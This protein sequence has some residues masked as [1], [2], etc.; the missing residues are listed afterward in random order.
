MSTPE[1]LLLNLAENGV[2]AGVQ[3]GLQTVGQ[4]AAQGAMNAVL[5]PQLE[6]FSSANE[7]RVVELNEKT[8]PIL[9]LY[10]EILRKKVGINTT[11]LEPGA[12]SVGSGVSKR[13]R[14]IASRLTHIDLGGKECQINIINVELDPPA[15]IL[16]RAYT[17]F[18]NTLIQEEMG[19]AKSKIVNGKISSEFILVYHLLRGLFTA[20]LDK[21]IEHKNMDGDL[22]VDVITEF[23]R[24]INKRKLLQTGVIMKDPSPFNKAFQTDDHSQWVDLLS[25]MVNSIKLL[26]SNDSAI[27]SAREYFKKTLLAIKSQIVIELVADLESDALHPDFIE[28]ELRKAEEKIINASSKEKTNN[29][30]QLTRETSQGLVVA[31]INDKLFS[32]FSSDEN[33][34]LK[35]E[36]LQKLYNLLYKVELIQKAVACFDLLNTVGGWA[37][38]LSGALKIDNLAVQISQCQAE[39]KTVLSYSPASKI[40]KNKKALTE[41]MRYDTTQILP[42][43]ANAAINRLTRLNHPTVRKQLIEFIGN[44]ILI[45]GELECGL[46]CELVDRDMLQQALIL[47]G[48]GNPKL[49]MPSKDQSKMQQA[50]SVSQGDNKNLGI[51]K[52]GESVGATLPN[53]VF[54][55]L[56]YQ[57]VPGDGHCLFHAVGLYLNKIQTTLRGEVAAYLNEHLDEFR[58]FLTPLLRSGQTLKMY[59]DDIKSGRESADHIE[60]EIIQRVT[61]QPIIIIR[62]NTNPTIPDLTVY[63]GEPIFIYYN[64]HNH[65]DSFIVV[66]GAN[67][68]RILNRIQASLSRKEIVAY[69]VALQLDKRF[70]GEGAVGPQFFPKS[71]SKVNDDSSDSSSS[72]SDSSINEELFSANIPKHLLDPLTNKL[73]V[74]P[75]LLVADGETYERESIEKHIREVGTIPGKKDKKIKDKTLIPNKGIKKAIKNYKKENKEREEEKKKIAE[76]N[77]GLKEALIS[78]IAAKALAPESIRYRKEFGDFDYSKRKF[79]DS[80]RGELVE[81]LKK[82]LLEGSYLGDRDIHWITD[83][84][85]ELQ[86]ALSFELALKLHAEKQW[87]VRDKADKPEL[88]NR[89]FEPKGVLGRN[90]AGENDHQIVKSSLEKRVQEVF[91]RFNKKASAETN[92]SSVSI[93]DP[94]NEDSS[95][96]LLP[97]EQK[98]MQ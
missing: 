58:V 87:V 63:T 96:L 55:G 30:T 82:V 46:D 66:G 86:E 51:S 13:L 4:G 11:S 36:R 49:I 9:E 59:I 60:I 93:N 73:M 28:N 56:Q 19:I 57:N 64:G 43:L 47:Q 14:A 23:T 84:Q 27:L 90:G 61:K 92:S 21:R 68:R 44:N 31:S 37:Y 78:N 42:K 39:C 85:N 32:E 91:S 18:L 24:E 15:E 7:T 20:A 2:R 81:L 17:D 50:K 69:Q 33:K 12:H 76:E 65:Y 40:F 54:H 72:E 1:S 95:Q 98:K 75:V 41:L 22:V 74:D 52:G 80:Q 97:L 62:P 8:K 83:N 34:W 89:L 94:D 70:Q 3:N 5:Q 71:R 6:E 38:I 88:G 16:Q 35:K 45:L 53:E 48:N 29:N 67:P 77:R 26:H 79:S 25:T 10:K